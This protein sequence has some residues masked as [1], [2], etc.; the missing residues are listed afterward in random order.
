MILDKQLKRVGFRSVELVQEPLEEAD[1]YG[2]GTTFL[3][4]INGVRMFM[5]GASRRCATNGISDNKYRV[6]LDPHAQLPH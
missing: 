2:K 5:G 1:R 6:E 4:E 3:F